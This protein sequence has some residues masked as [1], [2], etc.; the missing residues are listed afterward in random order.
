MLRGTEVHYWDYAP[1]EPAGSGKATDT[2]TGPAV[3]IAADL[4]AGIGADTSPTVCTP[5]ATATA[6]TILVVHG[7]RGDHHGLERLVE[8]LPQFR[9]I[10]PDLPGFGSSAAV[11][12][13]EHDVEQ[14]SR[15]VDELL[16]A[17]ELGPETVLLG[18]SFGSIVASHFTAGHLGRVS[19]LILINPIAAPALAGPNA[20]LSKLAAFYYLSA[21]KLPA[22]MGNALLRNALIVRL[23]SIT[24]AK[25]KDKALLEFIHG[26]HSAY[27]SIFANR[28][29][30]LQAFR[31]S[32]SGN[33]RQFAFRLGLPVLLVAGAE[34]EIAPLPDQHRLMEVLPDAELSVIPRVGHLIHYETP[35]PAAAA[36]SDFLKRHPHS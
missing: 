30:L 21:A 35:K 22:A 2:D 34:D 7:F 19:S 5:T 24:M 18:H 9:F 23:M 16:A 33:V 6:T 25:T 27:F 4:A 20:V 36:I 8:A 12:A 11:A 3:G 32:I 1:V 15:F 14:Y 26:Q 13:G 28:D 10:M 29:M 17:L 31:A